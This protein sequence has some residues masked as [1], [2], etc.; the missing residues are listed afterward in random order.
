MSGIFLGKWLHLSEF[1]AVVA[2]IVACPPRNHST[3]STVWCCHW[4]VPV[5]PEMP[6]PSCAC[7]D[8]CPYDSFFPKGCEW[9][10]CVSL[11]SPGYLS[12]CFHWLKTKDSEA[13]GDGGPLNER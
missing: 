13:Y 1:K 3:L 7:T 5:E 11:L 10:W 8:M 4:E 12:S 6:Y 9:R 2:E